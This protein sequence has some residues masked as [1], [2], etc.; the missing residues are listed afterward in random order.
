M[1]C[2]FNKWIAFNG[3]SVLTVKLLANRMLLSQFHLRA[4]SKFREFIICSVVFTVPTAIQV[5]FNWTKYSNKLKYED[6]KRVTIY[7]VF[8]IMHRKDM[9][10]YKFFWG[11]GGWNNSNEKHQFLPLFS[12]TFFLFP[13]W[14]LFFTGHIHFLNGGSFDWHESTNHQGKKALTK[15]HLFCIQQQKSNNNNDDKQPQPQFT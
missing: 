9:Q 2:E 10:T 5:H 8:I 11:G 15:Q 14:I 4:L 12:A 13:Y 1:D 7:Y 3:Y 6:D